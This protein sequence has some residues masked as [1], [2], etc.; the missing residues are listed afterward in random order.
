M[1]L[2]QPVIDAYERDGA[3][4]IEG[5]IGADWPERRAAMPLFQMHDILPRG[6]SNSPSRRRS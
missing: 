2:P 5:A 3:V 6:R 1:V 4:L